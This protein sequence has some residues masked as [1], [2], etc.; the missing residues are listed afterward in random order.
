[1]GRISQL[2]T[3][4]SNPAFNPKT[5]II[6]YKLHICSILTYASPS[7]VMA[8]CQP[9]PNPPALAALKALAGGEYLQEFLDKPNSEFFEKTLSSENPA[10]RTATT[11]KIYGAT[12]HRTVTESLRKL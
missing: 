2:Y 10:L 4:L 7:R 8:T 1:M 6:L 11:Q 9:H 5:G 3:L 12:E